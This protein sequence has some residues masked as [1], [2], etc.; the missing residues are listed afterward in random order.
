M[1]P[2][3]HCDNIGSYEAN[4]G[5]SLRKAEEVKITLIKAG[6][7]QKKIEDSRIT[8]PPRGREHKGMLLRNKVSANQG[9]I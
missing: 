8:Y 5:V 1:I 9:L 4:K 3:G 7:D 2:E 6:I